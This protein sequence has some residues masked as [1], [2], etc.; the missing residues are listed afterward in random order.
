MTLLSA[1]SKIMALPPAHPPQVLY[2]VLKGGRVVLKDI[3]KR[4]NICVNMSS[5]IKIIDSSR[6]CGYTEFT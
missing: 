6:S 1:V 5:Y 4:L 2:Y 3:G